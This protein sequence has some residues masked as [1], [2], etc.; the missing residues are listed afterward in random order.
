[1]SRG[2]RRTGTEGSRALRP[3][4]LDPRRGRHED[5]LAHDGD[6]PA[7]I[8]D[9]ALQFRRDALEREVVAREARVVDQ[10]DVTVV[11]VGREVGDV[12]V[13][14]DLRDLDQVLDGLTQS[15]AFALEVQFSQVD[16]RI[17]LGALGQPS[18]WL[19]DEGHATSLLRRPIA[20]TTNLKVS[21]TLRTGS[22][23]TQ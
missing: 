10:Q 11:H 16:V 4:D 6:V 20:D 2:S 7:A 21:R 1:A 12:L 13:A 14:V 18:E 22:R 5:V 3:V 15:P 8:P 19:F 23:N 17:R 9:R